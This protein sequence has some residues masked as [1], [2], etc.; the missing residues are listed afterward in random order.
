MRLIG[1]LERPNR[2]HLQTLR[3]LVPRLLLNAGRK[4]G[5]LV[6]PVATRPAL[7]ALAPET[8]PSLSAPPFWDSNLPN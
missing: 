5:A 7:G 8:L 3:A 4:L 2:P 6:L 1:L